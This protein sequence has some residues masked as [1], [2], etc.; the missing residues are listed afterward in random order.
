MKEKTVSTF[1]ARIYMAGDINVIKQVCRKYCYDVG[2]CVTV[3]PTSYIYTGGEE[4]GVIIELIN[5][6]RFPQ[7]DSQ[8][9]QKALD[10]AELCKKEACQQSYTILNPDGTFWKTERE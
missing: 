8:I 6:P 2:L 1:W 3:T 7:L 4:E 5:Y 9:Y 10:L